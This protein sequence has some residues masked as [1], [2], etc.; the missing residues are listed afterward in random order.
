[1]A[2]MAAVGPKPN[3]GL[4]PKSSKKDPVAAI[5]RTIDEDNKIGEGRLIGYDDDVVFSSTATAFDSVVTEAALTGAGMSSGKSATGDVPCWSSS[6]GEDSSNWMESRVHGE[7]VRTMRL[8][9]TGEKAAAD[10][11]RA[12][13]TRKGVKILFMVQCC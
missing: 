13:A 9:I 12:S 8:G 5:A 2:A 11:E 4:G 3:L 7:D 10:D 1:M 6:E